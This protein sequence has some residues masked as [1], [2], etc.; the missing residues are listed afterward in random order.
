ME[1]SV[2]EGY[3]PKA[4]IC[5]VSPNVEIIRQITDMIRKMPIS[6]GIKV[7]KQ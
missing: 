1:T 5:K 7:A 3:R 6:L 2:I 4:K